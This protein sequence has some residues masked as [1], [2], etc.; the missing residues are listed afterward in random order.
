MLIS[1]FDHIKI[2]GISVAVPTQQ[3]KVESYNNIFGEESVGK[4]SKMTGIKSV[5][6]SIPE[7]T[8][9]DLG[10]E[11]ACDLINKTGCNPDDIGILVFVTQKPDYRSPSTAYVL[12]KRIGL[13]KDCSCFDINMGC[14]GYVYGL[15]VVFSMLRNSDVSSALL[16]TGD[17]SIKTVSP[18]DRSAIMMFGDS[19][20]ATLIQ[21]TE[22]YNPVHIALR[23]DGNKF[24]AI[25]IP[26]G[27]YRNMDASKER[28]M[29]GDGNIRSD[30]D[31]F[32]NGTDVFNFTISEV[33]LMMKEFMNYL[34]TSPDTYD[35][36]ALHQA[37]VFIL[38]QLSRKLK[39]PMEKILIS[40]DKYGNISSNSIPLVL[41]DAYG[42]K[43]RQLVHTFMSGFGVG[44]SWGCVDIV[45][46]SDVIFP[47]IHTDEFY[48]DGGVSHF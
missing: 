27:A 42:K 32:V 2:A 5:Y 47:I 38:K 33:P 1:E 13:K 3:L 16:I 34:G 22:K 23:T 26:A 18:L 20:T 25:I 6:R 36:F 44:L 31:S 41:A 48:K 24:K 9:S 29:W 15:Q 7:Q 8:A 19:G 37:N 30:Y 4:F 11:A 12:H 28:V 17:T 10:Y 40:M 39:L 45:L 43:E 14:S 21:K 35:C 46:D